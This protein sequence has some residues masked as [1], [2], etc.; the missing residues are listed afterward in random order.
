MGGCKVDA[1]NA[2]STS[3]FIYLAATM[4]HNFLLIVLTP[5]AL[6][7]EANNPEAQHTKYTT[8]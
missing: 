6:R 4:N 3:L 1:Y 5:L 2:L 7:T 8:L